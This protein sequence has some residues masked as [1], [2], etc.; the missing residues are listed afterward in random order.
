M[1]NEFYKNAIKEKFINTLN[2]TIFEFTPNILKKYR[3]ST[4]LKFDYMY[5]SVFHFW[6]FQDPLPLF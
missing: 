6:L 3:I 4:L 1:E 2:A 5:Y